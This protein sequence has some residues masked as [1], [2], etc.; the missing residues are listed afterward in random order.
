[1]GYGIGETVKVKLPTRETREGEIIGYNAQGRGVIDYTIQL[2]KKKGD[3]VVVQPCQIIE[4]VK[5]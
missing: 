3:V 5:K 4:V 1:M 2:S